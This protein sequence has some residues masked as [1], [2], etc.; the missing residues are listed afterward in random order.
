MDKKQFFSSS[1][2]GDILGGLAAM[3]IALP[4]AVAFGII[5]YAPLGVGYVGKAAVAGMI[6]TVVLGIVA[7]IFGGTSRLVTAPCIPAAAVLAVFVA[8]H[9]KNGGISP[10]LIPF[11]VALVALMSGLVQFLS[12]FFAV[13]QF[14]KYIPYP[15]IAGYLNGVGI[16]ILIKQM[17]EFLGIPVGD[18]SLRTIL[19]P[20]IWGMHSIIIGLVT[21]IATLLTLKFFKHIPSAIVGLLFGVGAYFFLAIFNRDLLNAVDN[22]LIVGPISSS[23]RETFGTAIH[24][25]G[26]LSFDNIKEIFTH[27]IPILTLAVLLSMDTLK[28]CVIL[29]VLT[30][31]RHNSNK[32][33]V[34]QGL[35]NMASAILGGIPGAGSTAPTLI[36]MDSGAKTNRSSV[37]AGV[38][39]A[40]VLFFMVN[41]LVWI[42]LAALAGVLIVVAVRMLD[43]NSLQ[44]LRQKAT[45]FDFFVILAVVVAAVSTSLLIA[46]GVGTFL[47]IILFLREQIQSSVVRRKF[48]GNQKFSKKRRVTRELS[49]LESKGAETIICEL[50]GC[51][52][53]GTTDQ[54]LT[55]LEIYL[56][57]CL[58][59]VLDVRRVRSID[60][61]GVNMLKQIYNRIQERN[62]YLILTSVPRILSSGQ[63]LRSY[64]SSL[65]LK[66]NKD[67]KIYSDL[68]SAL[69]WIEDKIIARSLGDKKEISHVCNLSEFELFFDVP[70]ITL[71]KLSSV[72]IEKTFQPREKIFSM[73]DQ[74]DEIYFLRKGD[75]KLTLPLA[76][77]LYHH[78]LTLSQG[79]FFGEVSF[80]DRGIRSAEVVAV[81]EVILYVLSRN[82]FE[83][84]TTEYPEIEGMFFERLA[85][86]LSKRLRLTNIELIAVQ[87]S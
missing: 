35:A 44:L 46:A 21:I 22:P 76:D 2:V 45:L 20:S 87:E 23:L 26:Y 3:F 48:L 73:G 49:I 14:I 12:G 25:W 69:E 80:L 50:Q 82:E 41:L 42:P 55:E 59:V 85:R 5:L 16:L 61:T 65:G 29:D 77:G 24:Q 71:E 32:E 30:H 54:L 56:E 37:L 66:T 64:L 4:S 83:K 13:G 67:L 7:P 38:F 79:E 81:N 51:L 70:A 60:F 34:G 74:G 52:F 6:G 31:S 9:V 19:D 36:N 86:I 53:F 57:K 18:Y 28:T 27:I 40:I 47:A 10:D 15:V 84:I 11:Y 72:M 78:L 43:K 1:W 17:P 8:D 33:L 63:D 68:D 39:A 62:G 75:V 58:F